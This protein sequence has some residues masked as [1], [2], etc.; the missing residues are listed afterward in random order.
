ML[1]SLVALPLDMSGAA[2]VQ[3]VARQ[4]LPNRLADEESSE[5]AKVDGG[6]CVYIMCVSACTQECAYKQGSAAALHGAL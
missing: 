4:P 5:A 2:F 6:M 3:H 1:E